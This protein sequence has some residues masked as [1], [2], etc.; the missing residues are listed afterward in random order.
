MY[1]LYFADGMA[2]DTSGE[3]RIERRRD[4]LYVVGRGM[5][6]PVYDRADGVELIESMQRE[7]VGSDKAHDSDS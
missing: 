3:F 7:E 1:G 5:L 6:I 2:F 4:G